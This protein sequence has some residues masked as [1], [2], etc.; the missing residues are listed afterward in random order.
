MEEESV[1]F[2]VRISKA[3]AEDM[4][5]IANSLKI[6]RGEWFKYKFAE[7]IAQD[8]ERL[9][10]K[11]ERMYSKGQLSE[12][13]YINLTNVSPP[14]YTKKLREG[15]LFKQS[16]NRYLAGMMTDKEYIGIFG[17]HPP[18]SIKKKKEK[19]DQAGK[20]FYADYIKKIKE[21]Y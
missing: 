5:F 17:S 21:D 20:S 11:F 16:M 4:D 12:E 18:E 19:I 15:N 7:L 1:Q 13:E 6:S 8:K 2:N 3:I 9:M 10:D 14:D